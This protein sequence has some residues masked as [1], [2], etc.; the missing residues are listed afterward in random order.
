MLQADVLPGS[1]QSRTSVDAEP[2][3]VTNEEIAG[4]VGERHGEE[5]CAAFDV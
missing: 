3:N 4:A 5:E 1:A 2:V